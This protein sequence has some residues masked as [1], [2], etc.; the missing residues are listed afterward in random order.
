MTY[1]YYCDKC[2]KE[3]EDVFPSADRDKPVGQPCPCGKGG[4][5]KRGVCAPALSFQGSVSAIRK[6]GSGWN[7]VLTGIKKASG[8]DANIEHY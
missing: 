2:D 6:A 8:K 5:V 7:D 1:D 3:W 4:G